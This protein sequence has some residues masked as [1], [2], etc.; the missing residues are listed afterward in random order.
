M[1]LERV[2][3]ICFFCFLL[4]FEKNGLKKVRTNK[5]LKGTNWK[6]FKK[7]SL[8]DV[9]CGKSRPISFALPEVLVVPFGILK[10]RLLLP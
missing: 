6:I 7:V 5:I 4:N 9:Y 10:G 8:N 3:N 2:V 1:K